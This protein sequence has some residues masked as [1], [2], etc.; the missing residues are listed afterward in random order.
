MCSVV[1]SPAGPFSTLPMS[2]DASPDEASGT[3]HLVIAINSSVNLVREAFPD[4]MNA[5]YEMVE[6]SPARDSGK[7][8]LLQGEQENEVP[9]SRHDEGIPLSVGV[10]TDLDDLA[11]RFHC[12]RLR[13]RL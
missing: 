11:D 4:R 5:S 1:L 3:C 2:M 7:R 10:M 8:R 9:T 13:S 12:A 6:G